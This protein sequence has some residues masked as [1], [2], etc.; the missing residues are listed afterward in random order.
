MKEMVLA[1]KLFIGYS[2]QKRGAYHLLRV[3]QSLNITHRKEC[4]GREA[5]WL[6]LQGLKIPH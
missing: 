6:N 3:D 4:P 2:L 1:F 5:Y